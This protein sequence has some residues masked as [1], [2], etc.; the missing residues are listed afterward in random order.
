MQILYTVA[1]EFSPK[2]GKKVHDFLFDVFD[3]SSKKKSYKKNERVDYLEED[4][5]VDYLEEDNDW[6]CAN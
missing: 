3:F 4:N 6:K 5:G 1:S 2:F